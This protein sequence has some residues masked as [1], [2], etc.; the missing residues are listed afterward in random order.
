[1]TIF[2]FLCIADFTV[3]Q[4]WKA[5]LLDSFSPAS[6][7]SFLFLCP[8][9]GSSVINLPGEGPRNPPKTPWLNSIQVIILTV[10]LL[11][12]RHCASHLVTELL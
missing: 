5:K 6:T 9:E 10:V 11:G 8:A 4:S 3:Q 1:M 7:P 12:A 2:L